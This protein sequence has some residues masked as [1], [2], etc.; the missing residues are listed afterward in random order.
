M[1]R[2]FG[3]APIFGGVLLGI[4]GWFFEYAA[5]ER[6]EEWDIRC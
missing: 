2:L 6:A 3:V 5:Y 4:A 1:E